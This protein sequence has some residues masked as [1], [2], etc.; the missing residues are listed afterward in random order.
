LQQTFSFHSALKP[1]ENLVD[2]LTRQPIYL[3]RDKGTAAF[4]IRVLP[5]AITEPE[6]YQTFLRLNG[7][8]LPQEQAS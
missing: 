3:N 2:N 7:V 6:F 5:Y 1:I 8:T 4:H